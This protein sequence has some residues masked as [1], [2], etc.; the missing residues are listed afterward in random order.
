MTRYALQG[1]NCAGCAASIEGAL[2]SL[3]GVTAVR[4]DFA[5]AVAHVEGP[6]PAAAVQAAVAGLGYQAEPLAEGDAAPARER[7]AAE[8]ARLRRSFLLALPAAAA[9]AVLGM[10][11]VRGP[12]ADGAQALLA[13]AVLFGPGLRFHRAAWQRARHLEAGMDT[14]VSLGTLAAF[15]ASP[16]GLLGGG[17]LFFDSAAVIVALILLGRW[18]EAR[19]RARTGDAVAAL[20]GLAARS[21][22]LLVDGAEKAVPAAS[23]VPGDR[24]RVRPG[25]K[26]PAD[27]R[28][29]AGASA[30]DES[31]L[32]GESLPVEKAAGDTVIGGSLNGSGVLEVEVTAVGAETLLAGI[33]RAVERAQATRAP[34]QRL[35]DRIAAVFVPIVLAVAILTLAGWLLAGGGGEAALSAAVAVL[36]IACPCA[37]GLAT[38]TAILVGSGEGARRGILFRDAEVF[39]RSRQAD[40]VAFDKTGTLTEGR[41]SLARVVPAPGESEDGCLGPA[42]ALETASEHPLARAVVAGWRERHPGTALSAPTDFAAEAGRGVR[43]TVGGEEVRVGTLPWLLPEGAAP[44]PWLAEALAA[45]EEAGETAFLVEAGGRLRGLLTVADQLRPD[46]AGLVRSL[47]ARGLEAAILS[48]DRPGTVRAVAARAGVAVGEGGLLPADKA[49]WIEERRAAGRVVCFVGDGVN[50]APALAAADLGVALGSGSDVALE[51]GDVVLVGG[52]PS[53]LLGAFDLARLTLRTIRQNLF[54]AFAYNTL[55][56]PLAASG[57]LSPMIAAGAMAFS[58]LSVVLNSLLL[59]ARAARA[60]GPAAGTSANAGPDRP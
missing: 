3:E 49:A 48:G 44:P 8:A 16:A 39:E 4:V 14:L 25:E 12:V 47:A 29:V 59:R 55:A 10:G 41:M 31:L 11:G 2:R 23:L 56:I 60:L 45:A 9:V 42:A 20:A 5:Q 15:G 1:M 35:A 58:S 32:T 17:H 43:G 18:L 34:V 40:L 50:D 53:R 13:A 54:W 38:P 26:L 37:L 36:V 33:L 28:V 27:G 24:I 52:G 51:A 21:A 46:A 19:A 6:A 7:L 22:T 57:R 30:V